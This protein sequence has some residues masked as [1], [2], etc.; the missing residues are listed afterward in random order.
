MARQSPPSDTGRFE[1]NFLEMLAAERGAAENTL[2]SYR[3]DLARFAAFLRK[4]PADA[5]PDDIRKYLKSLAGLGMAPSTSARHLSTLRQFYRF[6]FSE[7]LRVDNPSTTIESARR[8]RPLPKV[9]SEGDV[10]RLLDTV[11][12]KAKA[13]PNERNLRL[14]VLIELLYATGL[15]VSELVG[16]P[17]SAAAAAGD[18]RYLTV[19]GKGGRERIVPLGASARQALEAYLAARPKPG[20]RE[21]PSKWLFPSRGETGHLTRIRLSQML[22]DLAAEAGIEPRKVSPHVLRHAFASH[23]L[24]HGADLRAVQQMLGHA[25]IS[26]T[27]IYTHVLEERLKSLVNRAHPLA[28]S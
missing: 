11:H 19:R 25:D 17:A 15:R 18:P 1:D 26:T 16:L 28:Q 4:D 13:E 5:G 20:P 21:T 22:K 12:A 23:L 8:R 7:G 2:E 10:G 9:L 24:A 6:L 14:A 3:R 27:E